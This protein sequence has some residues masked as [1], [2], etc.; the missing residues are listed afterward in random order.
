MVMVNTELRFLVSAED[1][2]LDQLSF[3]FSVREKP[4]IASQALIT[5][6]NRNSAEFRWMPLANDAG[7]PTGSGASYSFI[8]T[9]DDGQGGWDEEEITIDVI[10]A[11]ET[12]PKEGLV[13]IQ[14][15]GGGMTL[16]LEKSKCIINLQIEVKDDSTPTGQMTLVINQGVKGAYLTP[17]NNSKNKSFNWCP[18]Q[19][20]IETT[21]NYP[22]IFI[23]DNQK[24]PPIKKNYLI[25][26]QVALKTDSEGCSGKSPQIAHTPPQDTVKTSGDFQ[27]EAIVTDDSEIKD[28]PVLYYTLRDLDSKALDHPDL[29]LFEPVL[30][31]HQDNNQYMAK[32]VDLEIKP[33]QSKKLCYLIVVTDNDSPAD[34]TC[35]HRT[36]SPVYT[37]NLQHPD[38]AAS[39]RFDRECQPG[40]FCYQGKCINSS[41]GTSAPCPFSLSCIPK[42]GNYL[43]KDNGVCL[44][45]CLSK[46]D[47]QT[48]QECKHFPGG[49]HGCSTSGSKYLGDGCS[50]FKECASNLYCHDL[51]GGLCTMVDCKTNH[52]CVTNYDCIKHNSVNICIDICS[53]NWDCRR[54]ENYKCRQVNT[55][56]NRL[57]KVCLP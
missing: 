51:T 36:Q 15:V 19:Q 3:T 55:V 27:V 5:R 56:D 39:C 14:P 13:F 22:L 24:T 41:C 25:R 35:N 26:L 18:T 20:Q 40:E 46:N 45:S 16:D 1:P 54:D 37:I 21:S 31:Q 17:N 49:K 50:S 10:P 34:P 57:S 33:G 38:Q 11:V 7:G 52:Q 53:S 48:G 43:K 32:I 29:N 23:A 6:Q 28:E 42:Q 47:C 8:F 12:D 2:D 44:K 30:F 4:S 9:V